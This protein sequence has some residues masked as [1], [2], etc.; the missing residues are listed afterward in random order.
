MNTIY[1]SLQ[2]NILIFL[3]ITI[4]GISIWELITV[5]YYQNIYI[6]LATET[7]AF[8]FTLINSILNIINILF[9]LWI[10]DNKNN[11][12]DEKSNICFKFSEE[13]PKCSITLFIIHFC[14][15]IWSI[16]LFSNLKEY[17]RFKNIIITEFIIFLIEF[18]IIGFLLIITIY[19]INK[20]YI[21][22]QINI[23]EY[24]NYLLSKKSNKILHNELLIQ[25][26]D[27]V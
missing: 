13:N 6:I 12:L 24:F 19:N 9:L 14:I 7:N 4:F 27:N 22:E 10:I 16:I 20:T 3:I 15:G 25:K 21:S 5:S 17:K 1:N 23:N 18:L 8:Y 11:S 26:L 2:I